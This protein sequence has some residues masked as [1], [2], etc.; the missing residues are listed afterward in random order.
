MAVASKEFEEW[1]VDY[2]KAVLDELGYGGCR[3]A[4]KCN[5]ASEVLKL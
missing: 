1:L 5:N 2:L 4:I 3:V